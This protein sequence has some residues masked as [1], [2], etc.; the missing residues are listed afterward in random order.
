MLLA[1]DES[2]MGLPGSHCLYRADD[3]SRFHE[4]EDICVQGASW[5]LIWTQLVVCSCAYIIV[6]AM[7]AIADFV[8]KRKWGGKV[9]EVVTRVARCVRA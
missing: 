4:G 1:H 5:S 8:I 3:L 7:V 6:G 9:C 2:L